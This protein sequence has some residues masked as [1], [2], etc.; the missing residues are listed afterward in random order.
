MKRDANTQGG[1]DGSDYAPAV[2][3]QITQEPGN[4]A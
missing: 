1:N 3:K 4:T 2:D